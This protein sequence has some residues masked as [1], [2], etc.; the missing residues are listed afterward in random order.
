MGGTVGGD[1]IVVDIWAD[2]LG[3]LS[4][5]EVVVLDVNLVLRLRHLVSEGS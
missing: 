5:V 2:T 3:K 1:D 4:L